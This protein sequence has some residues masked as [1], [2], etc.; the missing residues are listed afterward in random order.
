MAR[1][2]RIDF[3]GGHY[4]ITARGVAGTTIFGDDDDRLDFLARLQQLCQRFG[5]LVHAYCLMDT[6]YHLELETPE[7]HLSRSMQW[8]NET[9]ASAFNRRYRRSGYLFQGRFHSAVIEAESYLSALTRYIHLNP[10]RAGMVRRPWK[11]DWSSCRAYLGMVEPPP[12]LTTGWVLERFGRTAQEQREG[13]LQFLTASDEPS[14]LDAVVHGALL[15]GEDFV[16]Q[17]RMQLEEKPL[18][19]E[20]SR[21]V[22]A[23][24]VNP[25]AVARAVGTTYGCAA[26]HLRRRGRKGD[27]A[28]DVAIYLTWRHCRLTNATIGER[29]GGIKAAAVS[30][31][32]RRVSDAI[33]GDPAVAQRIRDLEAQLRPK[34]ID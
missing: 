29:F 17:M 20:V 33:D 6:H 32:C 31:A 2:L 26:E 22:E 21:M 30:H 24:S 34:I 4:H 13:Y 1:P 16:R 11:Y 23:A 18:D 5:V 27:E 25:E 12:W 28:R 3:P 14:P 7:G 8:L 9:Y 10:V 19:T 15:G